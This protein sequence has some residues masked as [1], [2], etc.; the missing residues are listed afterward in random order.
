MSSVELLVVY[1]IAKN[2]QI[3]LHATQVLLVFH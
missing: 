2:D 1:M 3:T